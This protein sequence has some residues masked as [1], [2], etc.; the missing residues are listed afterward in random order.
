MSILDGDI[1]KAILIVKPAS[2]TPAFADKL[3]FQLY[4]SGFI[5]VREE[6]RDI[7]AELATKITDGE[8]RD[9]HIEELTG[10]AYLFV[11][12]RN[13]CATDLAIFANENGLTRSC[14]FCSS[15]ATAGPAVITLFPRMAVDAIPSSADA[16]EYVQ[17]NLKLVLI[18]GLT[19]VAKH[20]PKNP[21]DW[22]ANYLLDNNLQAPAVVKGPAH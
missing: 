3:R 2:A 6:S 18:K 12:A 8:I 21:I 17:E 9:N 10:N 13:N 4:D 5:V 1:T 19:E 14:F 15:A 11:V 20:K 22:L 16:R 7:T